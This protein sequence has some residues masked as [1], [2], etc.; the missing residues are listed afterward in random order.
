[1]FTMSIQTIPANGQSLYY[2]KLVNLPAFNNRPNT[3]NTSH[4]T[5][6]SHR[7]QP[8][9][10]QL[11]TTHKKYSIDSNLT[12]SY[13]I[14]KQYSKEDIEPPINTNTQTSPS[15]LM[16]KLSNLMNRTR[17]STND[18]LNSRSISFSS[19][20]TSSSSSPI[21]SNSPNLSTSKRFNTNNT[22]N[23]GKHEWSYDENDN[24][25]SNSN[26]NSN[27]LLIRL[28]SINIHNLTI[29][30]LNCLKQICQQKLQNFNLNVQ[31][32]KDESIK[33]IKQNHF[34]LRS[35]SVVYKLAFSD[36]IKSFKGKTFFVQFYCLPLLLSSSRFHIGHLLNNKLFYR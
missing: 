33:S 4:D 23:D 9:V 20:S 16:S 27:K 12:K 5:Y 17:K 29:F 11:P 18:L 1:M 19:N 24:Y 34:A 21:A 30:E 7:V 10:E 26:T 2:A 22:N 35:K 8:T 25:W 15:T 31:I 13:L 3:N 32:P 6:W 36:D 28:T 14:A